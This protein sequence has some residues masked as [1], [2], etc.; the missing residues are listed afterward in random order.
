MPPPIGRP[1]PRRRT[2]SCIALDVAAGDVPRRSTGWAGTTTRTT[3]PSRAS[4]SWSCC[5][6]TTRSRA[7]RLTDSAWWTT[8]T[9]VARARRSPSST[10]TWP[11][12]RRTS[13]PTRATCWA[14]VSDDPGFNDYYDFT[15]GSTQSRI[16]AVSSRCRGTSQPGE[17]RW[18][19]AQGCG[20]RLPLLPPNDGRPGSATSATDEPAIGLDGPQWVLEYWSQLHNVFN[21]VRV[22]DIALRQAAGHGERRLRLSTRARHRTGR[23][24][25]WHC[26]TERPR[27]EDGARPGQPEEGE[28]A[29]R[30]RGG[31]RRTRQ[32][33]GGDPSA[34]QHRDDADGDPRDRG[35]GRHPAVPT[36]SAIRRPQQRYNGAADVRPVL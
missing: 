3:S 12:T 6:A 5:P 32:D 7:A 36:G 28:L 9:A 15:P 24:R 30:V 26:S 22:E 8:A 27:V 14:F 20:R 13:S 19:P 35:P 34:G 16:A 10:R 33:A 1:E 21:F 25:P 11:G 31:R 4:T 17:P 29:E 23:R 2:A 18:S